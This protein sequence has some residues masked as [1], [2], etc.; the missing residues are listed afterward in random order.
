MLLGAGLLALLLFFAPMAPCE[1]EP[2]HVSLIQLIASPDKYHG[3]FIRVN[4]YLHNKFE[5]S[6]LYLGKTDGDYLIC[7]NAV[8]IDFAE[9]V[10][11]E[12]RSEAKPI[13]ARYFDCKYV[14][15]EGRFNKNDHGHMDLAAGS[16]ENVTRVMELTHWYDGKRDLEKNK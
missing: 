11:L 12:P 15:V 5:D 2:E 14:L 3:R 8:W 10:R 1:E 9:K 7:K 16:I 4:G 13:T 6:A